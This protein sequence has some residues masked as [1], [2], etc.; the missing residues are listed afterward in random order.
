MIRRIVVW[1]V[2]FLLLCPLLA[3][4][5]EGKDRKKLLV[6]G[7]KV[8]TP[9]VMKTTTGEWTGISIDLWKE[10]ASALDLSYEFRE[11]DLQG[12]LAGVTDGSLNVAVA[13]LTITSEREE[14][15]DFTHPFLTSGLGIAISGQK[16]SPWWTVL[17][18][19]LSLAFLKV[20]ATLALVLLGGGGIGM[21]V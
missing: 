18:K 8:V 14:R 1:W 6:V 5:E 19:F 21:V 7:T 9:F 4:S 10:I 13:A 15:F 3:A 20:V 17:R 12:L 11:L 16:G 2:L